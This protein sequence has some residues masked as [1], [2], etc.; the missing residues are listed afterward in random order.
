MKLK[1]RHELEFNMAE[2]KTKKRPGLRSWDKKMSKQLKPSKILLFFFKQD[3]L[4]YFFKSKIKNL[5][6]KHYLLRQAFTN[7]SFVRLFR[8]GHFKNSVS[9]FFR[10]AMTLL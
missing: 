2:K 5:K 3:Y 7:A 10:S 8:V 1:L 9:K 4:K 6:I